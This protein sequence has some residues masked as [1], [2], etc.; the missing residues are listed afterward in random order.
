MGYKGAVRISNGYA[1]ELLDNNVL[2]GLYRGDKIV[3]LGVIETNGWPGEQKR[4]KQISIDEP[5][6]TYPNIMGLK[7]ASK[8]VKNGYKMVKSKLSGEKINAA[9][10][11][12]KGVYV[13][14]DH[15]KQ[16]LV[17]DTPYGAIPIP[18][19]GGG[20]GYNKIDEGKIC[21]SEDMIP[22][23]EGF[24]KTRSIIKGY[25]SLI[26]NILESN[27]A[28]DNIRP[29][30]KYILRAYDKEDRKMD[31]FA[32]NPEYATREIEKVFAHEV[33]HEVGKKTGLIDYLLKKYVDYLRVVPKDVV[34]IIEQ[35]AI[36]LTGRISG[37]YTTEPETTYGMLERDFDRRTKKTGIE[38]L[39][40][41]KSAA[42]GDVE[43]LDRKTEILYPELPRKRR[44][45]L[46]AA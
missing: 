26:K 2:S 23:T 11:P 16:I 19:P 3:P 30:L 8:A 46:K 21:L 6:E 22:G 1:M 33:A 45:E 36:D 40:L 18:L 44:L 24:M 39:S 25:K 35:N 13:S 34:N 12:E 5:A 31:Y 32:K 38:G 4:M 15:P 41:V 43:G 17:L 28:D 10:E 14:N 20:L 37:V 29:L 42:R 9:V 27:L 7:L